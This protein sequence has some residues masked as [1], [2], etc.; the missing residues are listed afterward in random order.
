[1]YLSRLHPLILAFLGANDSFLKG[2]QRDVL[3]L[4]ISKS[5]A[6]YTMIKLPKSDYLFW[7][8]RAFVFKEG[9]RSL[10]PHQSMSRPYGHLMFYGL[11]I[12]ISLSNLIKPLFLVNFNLIIWSLIEKPILSNNN[13]KN[14]IY[15]HKEIQII[16]VSTSVTRWFK[17]TKIL[18]FDEPLQQYNLWSI[19]RLNN[20]VGFEV[21]D[22]DLLH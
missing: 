3:C 2:W 12:F 14:T 4:K 6:K 1:M 11:T 18:K 5:H 9:K 7:E 10:G 16:K 22:N 20:W 17:H 19:L 13:S 21:K 15:K 8:E